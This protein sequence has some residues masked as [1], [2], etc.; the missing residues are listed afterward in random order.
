MNSLSIIHAKWIIPVVPDKKIYENHALVFEQ[1]GAQRAGQ[2]KI[3]DILP[4]D[5]C[6]QKYP[7]QTIIK[8]MQHVLIPGLVNA[9]THSP[10]NLLRG[11]ADDLPLMEWLEKHIWPAEHKYV[12]EQFIEH[13]SRLA[14]AEM[15]RSGSTTFN[16]MYFFP[17]VTARIADQVGIRAVLGQIII[18][19]P[20]VW[21]KDAQEYLHKG[22]QLHK[23]YLKHPL[24]S[25]VL[26]P[27]APYTVSDENLLKVKESA[28]ELNTSIHIHLHETEDEINGS[29][30]QHQCRPI[31]R[32]HK[33]GLITPKLIAV[34]MTHLTEDDIE[35]L[36][37][38]KPQLVHCPESNMKLASGI[39]PVHRLLKQGLNIALG[40]DGAAS[41]NDLNMLGE[42][43]SAS[44][45]S[46]VS[47]SDATALNAE[48][49]LQMAT[50]NGARVLGLEDQIGSLEIGKD[51]DI[52]AIDMDNI[53][54]QP[55]YHPLSQL[56][57]AAGRENVSDVWVKG[58]QLLDN[59]NLTTIDIQQVKN[60]CQLWHNKINQFS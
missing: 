57:Y 29:I 8:R 21:A 53:E 5:E 40:T 20:S 55:I 2:G 59:K 18:D 43:R 44:F 13:G 30:Q 49:V 32:L 22:Q 4:I 14:M 38:Q 60:D 47:T 26:A 45:L 46:K 3:I 42:M 12:N 28:D 11:L 39:S 6:E 15:L 36:L 35:L 51:A 9:H 17:N 33:L 58:K 31:Q 25:T 34:H 19:F 10:M 37:N 50:I 1:R 16:D 56:V 52:C 7:C 41:N 27:H 48:Q 24:I 54:C 23:Q